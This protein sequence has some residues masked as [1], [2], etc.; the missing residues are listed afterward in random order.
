MV[1]RNI[2]KYRTKTVQ[3]G[4]DRFSAIDFFFPPPQKNRKSLS[5]Q[6]Y[7]EQGGCPENI[8][9]TVEREIEREIEINREK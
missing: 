8:C 1:P 4:H 5:R 3:L 6:K 7:P 2:N 9:F